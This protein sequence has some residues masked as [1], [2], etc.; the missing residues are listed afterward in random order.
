MRLREILRDEILN[1]AL[2]GY[3]RFICGAAMGT[4]IMFG[5]QVLSIQAERHPNIRLVC[6]IPHP[7]QAKHWPERWQRRYQTLLEAANESRLIADLFTRGCYHRRNRWMVDQ[8][9]AVLAIWD[10]RPGG[11]T[12]YT[13]EYAMKMKKGIVRIDPETLNRIVL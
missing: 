13:V 6:A 11:G 9:D 8:S 4:D 2:N 7:N 5:E 1:A 3:D 12:A 10:G